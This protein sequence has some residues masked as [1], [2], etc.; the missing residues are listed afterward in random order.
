M[1]EVYTVWNMFLNEWVNMHELFLWSCCPKQNLYP[2]HKRTRKKNTLSLQK[3]YKLRPVLR[4]VLEVLRVVKNTQLNWVELLLPLLT[5]HRAQNVSEKKKQ[6]PPFFP[7]Y[8]LVPQQTYPPFRWAQNVCH[9]SSFPTKGFL[10]PTGIC[11]NTFC[12]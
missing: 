3:C 6:F 1:S 8:L 10:F 7:T 5:H 2:R 11:L 12:P 4:N 9:V